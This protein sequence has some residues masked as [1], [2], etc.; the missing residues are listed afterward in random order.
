MK[1]L[2]TL[3][4]GALLTLL[5]IPLGVVLAVATI[6]PPAVE[7]ACQGPPGSGNPSAS[8]SLPG[9]GSPRR[10]SLNN[11]PAAIPAAVQGVYERAAS[12]FGL[13]WVLL[14]GVGMEETRH[15]AL[16]ATSSA[17]ARGLMQFMPGT[18][19]QYGIDGN[20]DGARDIDD[21][22]DSIFSAA[23]YLVALGAR[24]GD[25]G[26]R[27]ALFGYNHASWY[28]NDVLFYA[29]A[30]T[31]DDTASNPCLVADTTTSGGPSVDATGPASAAV[32]AALR[33]VGTRYSWGGGNS[34]GPTWGI[35]CSPG[36]QDAR[37]IVGFD[38]SGLVLYAYAQVGVRLPH[39]AHAITHSSGGQLI[40][41]AFARMRVG[42]AIGFSY[43]PGGRVFHVGLYLGNGTMVN[44]DGHGVSIASLTRGYYSR[45]AW[46]IVRFIP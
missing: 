7:A 12:K 33:W 21:P 43:R 5:V 37:N 10:A 39:L 27:T 4:A 15:G 28:V 22:I 24:N 8:G 34:S 13:P 36:G 29:A 31:G 3:L 41:R 42:D 6:T 11:P 2:A 46:R 32:K 19:A 38:C 17:G 26:V 9:P 20:G 25:D 45:L 40:S 18:W 44:A 35:C 14:A 1:V 23:N 16:T 30:Y